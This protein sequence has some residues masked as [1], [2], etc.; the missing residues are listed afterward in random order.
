MANL[1]ITAASVIKGSD[2]V[3]ANGI[4]GSATVTA[5]QPVYKLSTDNK[6]Y[7]TDCDVTAVTANSEIDNIYGIALHGASASQPLSVQ[8]EGSITIGATVAVGVPYVVSATAG[9]ICP[10]TDLVA[11]DYVSV[12]GMGSSTSVIKIKPCI[13]GVQIPAA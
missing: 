10:W 13:S 5:G 3:V 1:V 8:T 12:I 7:L 9:S 4:C 2:A 6:F 11:T